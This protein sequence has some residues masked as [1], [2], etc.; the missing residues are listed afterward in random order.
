MSG[1]WWPNWTRTGSSGYERTPPRGRTSERS[2]GP[3]AGDPGRADHRCPLQCAYC[4]N[5]LELV[6]A[7][8]ELGTE[9]WQ[10]VIDEAA[11]LGALQIH[12]SGGEPA[13]RRDL[14][15]LVAPC[16]TPELYTNLIT[17]GVSLTRRLAAARVEAGLD[18]VQL[19]VQDA[20]GANAD[21]I[22]GYDRGFRHARWSSRAGSPREA[23]RSPSMP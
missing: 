21:R 13:A 5:P 20:R 9:A 17:S 14:A 8:E 1:R 4:S 22:A 3:A 2:L 11:A 23:C 10:R 7:R 15:Q 6:A 16:A 18:H 12:F 19:S